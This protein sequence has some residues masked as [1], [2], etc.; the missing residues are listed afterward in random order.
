APGASSAVG[1]PGYAALGEQPQRE[2]WS[3]P[4]IPSRLRSALRRLNPEVPRQYL[5]QAVA[6]ILRAEST[7]AIAENERI[8]RYLTEGYR[9]TYID[10]GRERSPSIRLIG[11]APD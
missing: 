4:A 11:A 1:H 6:E 5:D 2:S 7:D 9:L 10:E 8:H 3:E